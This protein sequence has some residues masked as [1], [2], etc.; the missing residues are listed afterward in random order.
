MIRIFF[1]IAL[2]IFLT[3]TRAWTHTNLPLGNT[4]H[5]WQ[6]DPAIKSVTSLNFD[7]HAGA[8]FVSWSQTARVE[9]REG[10]KCIIG[11]YILFDIDEEFAF[12]TD[13]VIYLDLTFYRPETDGYIL[14]YDQAVKPTAMQVR[15][16]ENTSGSKWHKE[17]VRLERARFA[18]RK[19]YGND[20]AIGGIGSQL[21]HPE[22]RGEAVL[23]DIKITRKA[24]APSRSSSQGSFTLNITDD[25]GKP[26]AARV[27]L[28]RA[29]GWAPIAGKDA[30]PVERYTEYTRELPMVSVP[31]GWS[32]NG[33]YIFFVDGKYNSTIPTGDYQLFVMK[34]PEFQIH[35]SNIKIKAGDTQSITVNL[36]RFDNLQAQ[37]W[38]SGDDHI[39]ISRTSDKK[40]DTILG[41]MKAEDIQ[42]ANLLQAANIH[43]I[44]FRQYNFGDGGTY[45]EDGYSLVSGQESPRTSHRGHTIGLN[46]KKFHKQKKEYFIYDDSA[47]LIHKDGGLW[48]YAHVAIDAFNIYNGLA[49]DVAR[50]KV[51][52]LEMAQYGTL[53]TSYLYDFLNM[54]FKLAPSAGSDYPYI[55]FPGAE[56]LYTQVTGPLTAK[57]WFA[58]LKSGRTFITN[59]MSIDFSVNGDKRA[60]EY[61]IKSGDAVSIEALVKVNPDFDHM[62]R[63]EL[64][65]HGDV[66]HTV[67]AGK[68]LSKLS[69]SH[70]FTPKTS[71][72]LA[73]RGFGKG[74][75]LLHTT[76]IY[77]YVDGNNDFSNHQQAALL[78]QKNI[79]ILMRFR[80]STP[81]LD[82]EF[83]RFAVEDLIQPNWE[84][85]KGRLGKAIDEAI[86]VYKKIIADNN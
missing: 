78:A 23:C 26:T 62:D 46:V 25:T 58:A 48:G 21:T 60:V 27:G 84:L 66:I 28:Y 9:V 76:T 18:N 24:K 12:D 22:G 43:E 57:S 81:S 44:Y 73:I 47:D 16:E 53:N 42:V 59:W 13:E 70:S 52:F 77:I 19:Y 83:E 61:N 7:F 17:T 72:W 29:D 8:N 31:K 11:A 15:F 74:G 55:D 1:V 38:L 64:V 85:S 37:G 6:P 69:L 5:D 51:D 49:L 86:A 14:S 3:C 33:R 36:K 2:S 67:Y 68:D 82:V 50:G 56:R 30:I 45:S 65:A 20:L 71:M 80:N 35:K 34:G 40:N 75:A 41:F 4:S 32:E 54:G 63:I 10:K 79:D 39:H